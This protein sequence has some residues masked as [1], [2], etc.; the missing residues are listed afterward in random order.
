MSEEYTRDH[1]KTIDA[2]RDILLYR[3]LWRVYILREA[4]QHRQEF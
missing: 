3:T 1:L 2:D 4:R